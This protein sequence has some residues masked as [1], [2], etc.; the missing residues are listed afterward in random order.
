MRILE[1]YLNVIEWGPGIY[2]AEAAARVY[3]NKSAAELSLPEAIHLVSVLPNPQ[4]FSPLDDTNEYTNQREEEITQGLLN[5]GLINRATYERILQEKYYLNASKI[6]APV[7]VPSPKVSSKLLNSDYWVSKLSEP[8]KIIMSKEEIKNFNERALIMSGGI[9]VFGL[10]DFLPKKEVTDEILEVAGLSPIFPLRYDSNNN[11]LT[12]RFYNNLLDELNL[13]VLPDKVHIKYALVI[14]RTD[15]LAWPMD[16]LIMSK[17]YDY[18]FNVLQQ[19]AIYLSTPVAV[20]HISRDG[21]WAFIRTSYFDGWVKMKNLAWTTREEAMAYPGSR[22]LVVTDA[23]ART[24]LGVNLQMGTPVTIVKTSAK[25]YEVKIPTRGSNGELILSDDFLTSVGVRE[26]FLP[27][28]KRNIINQAFK[29]LDGPYSWGGGKSGWDCSLFIQDVFSVFGIKPPRN[30]SWQAKVSKEIAIFDKDTPAEDKLANI[31]L[32]EPATTLL[33]LPGH[34]MLYLGED[35]GKPF[36]IH[37]IWG[38]K[39]K[40]GN[41]IKVNQVTVTDLDLGQGGENG[42]L[43]ERINDVGGVYLDS[44]DLPA[45]VKDFFNW[46]SLHTHLVIWEFAFI[47]NI[48]IMGLFIIIVMRVLKKEKTDA[49]S[50][51]NH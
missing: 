25:G 12:K 43:I 16:E 9:D 32:W 21:R 17:P 4:R 18:E 38:V 40:N 46:L 20:F 22:F 42:S 3:F 41:V 19:S 48:V 30:S 27:Y 15:V 37:S 36:A 50:S 44:T 26:D 34:I 51:I 11:P 14:K 7:V 47:I 10:P 5:H 23:S 6:T 35:G 24:A 39:D 29:L 49:K 33:G 8:D 1:L 2:G 28:T 13:R 45:L 31:H